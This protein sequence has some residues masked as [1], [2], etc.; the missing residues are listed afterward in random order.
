MDIP[1]S[2][3][4]YELLL[5][6]AYEGVVVLF[7]EDPSRVRRRLIRLT[8]KPESL[9]RERAI[10]ALRFLSEHRGREHPEFFRETIRRHLWGMNEEGG[11]IDWSAPEIIGAIIAG[12]PALFGMF[13]SFMVLAALEEPTFHPSLKAATLLIAEVD[14]GLVQ[15]FLPTVQAL[16]TA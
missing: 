16:E 7:D 5:H 13:T 12:Q 14:E 6:Q 1:A 11:N 4:L 3:E 8:Y 9:L 10:E 2:D 15:E